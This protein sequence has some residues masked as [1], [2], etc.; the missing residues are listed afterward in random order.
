MWRPFTNLTSS[1]ILSTSY[2][3]I[4]VMNPINNIIINHCVLDGWM[5]GWKMCRSCLF[6]WDFKTLISRAFKISIFRAVTISVASSLRCLCCYCCHLCCYHCC[7]CRFPLVLCFL[8][9]LP[10]VCWPSSRL[11]SWLLACSFHFFVRSSLGF[12]CQI[13]ELGFFEKKTEEKHSLIGKWIDSFM[14]QL[15]QMSVQLDSSIRVGCQFVGSFD[16]YSSST[17]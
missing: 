14:N 2:Q 4:E 5:D 15:I 3:S 13:C 11:F 6:W 16:S 17:T 8:G 1:P 7:Y 10:G 12:D 9:L